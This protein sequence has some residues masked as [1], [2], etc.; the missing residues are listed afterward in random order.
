[1]KKIVSVL[2]VAA[3]TLSAVFAA[4]ITIEY[5]TLGN[6]YSE[7]NTETAGGASHTQTRTFLDQDGYGKA[8]AAMKV[9]ATTDFA[10]FVLS[11]KPDATKGSGDNG[12]SKIDEYY[13]FMNFGPLQLTTG[14]WTSR[15]INRVTE[16]AGK[17]E[18]KDFEKYK[19]GVVAFTSATTAMQQLGYAKDIDNLTLTEAGAQELATSLALT[20]RPNDDT[21]FLVKGV[22]IDGAG[23]PWGGTLMNDKGNYNLTFMSGF[24]GEVA[25]KINN[26]FDLNFVAKSL[27]RD[28]L[29]MGVFFRPLM[30]G[31]TNMLL[32][33]SY[34]TFIDKS[35]TGDKETYDSWAHDMGIDFR[36]RFVLSDSLALTTM[37]NLSIATLAKKAN[38][39]DAKEWGKD[40]AGNYSA[41]H[42]WNMV[43][44]AYK[45]NEKLTL[46]FTVH[47][48]TNF[49]YNKNPDSTSTKTNKEMWA[50]DCGGFTF[51]FVPGIV[52]KFSKNASVT[53]GVHIEAPNCFAS[54]DW[55]NKNA[56]T[57]N[58]SIP[59]V[60][61]VAL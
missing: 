36:A 23:T 18:S 52:Y 58:I 16:D 60:F 29:A 37:N 59:F 38:V 43:S 44:L 41:Y 56:V 3:L 26:V 30:L 51:T 48:E 19:P 47:S 61:D 14:N 50:N 4:D 54:S 9:K 24:A 39:A 32:G 10:G 12:S 49:G 28:H 42:L 31:K 22:A 5:K 13:G 11:F 55:L 34:A 33:F 2:S 27:K 45:T 1:M 17:W 20:I 40:E 21:Y 8:Q 15:Y 7:T 46:Q 6:I 35:K 57:Q 25:L 53:A